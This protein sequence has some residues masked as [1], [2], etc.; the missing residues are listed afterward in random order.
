MSMVEPGSTLPGTAD[1]TQPTITPAASPASSGK[2]WS[3]YSNNKKMAL[4]GGAGVVVGGAVYL[5]IRHKRNTATATAAPAPSSASAT[6]AA[7]A[8]LR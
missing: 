2:G 8:N 1:D 3:S 7:I 5:Y 6:G 4:A